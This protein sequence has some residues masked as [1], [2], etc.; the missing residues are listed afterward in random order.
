MYICVCVYIYS[1]QR[2][3]DIPHMWKAY[4]SVTI[5]I[6]FFLITYLVWENTILLG[7]FFRQVA[8]GAERFIDRFMHRL[9]RGLNAWAFG[10]H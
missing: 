7:R 1:R 6:I 2:I 3:A 9:S 8:A 5:V 4:K 10:D